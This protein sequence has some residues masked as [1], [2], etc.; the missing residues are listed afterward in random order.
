MIVLFSPAK[1]FKTTKQKT[2][3]K[4]FFMTKTLHLAQIIKTYTL[5]D[6]QKHFHVSDHIASDVYTYYHT[7]NQ[8]LY[9]AV[10]LYD[11]TS[12]KALDVG[13]FSKEERNFLNQH[14]YIIS[15]L[16]GLLKPLDM[17][18]KYRLDFY[19]KSLG[20]LYTYWKDDLNQYLFKNHKN[21]LK[22]SLLS[23]EFEKVIDAKKNPYIQIDFYIRENDRLKSPSMMLKKTRGLFLNHII[24]KQLKTIDDIKALTVDGYRYHNSES[25]NHR[26]VFIKD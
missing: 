13:S 26:L 18:S 12:Y 19:H 16:Y 2:E 8:T 5:N 20:N 3:Q 24:K 14:V 4:P 22:I 1:T 21:D 7:F 11:G 9:P 15:A 6:I 25:T 23:K 17:I 10:D